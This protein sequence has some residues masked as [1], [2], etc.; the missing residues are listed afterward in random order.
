MLRVWCA[1]NREGRRLAPRQGAF[2]SKLYN[3]HPK[4]HEPVRRARVVRVD[5]R[6]RGTVLC[7]SAPRRGCGGGRSVAEVE[8]APC[9]CTHHEEQEEREVCVCVC[10]YV[11]VC[12]CLCVFVCLCVCVCVCVCARACVCVCVIVCSCSRR[13]FLWKR[14]RE[15]KALINQRTSAISAS[16]DTCTT[17]RAK[18]RPRVPCRSA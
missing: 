17:P 1:A 16:F 14:E 5:A 12:L 7:R 6:A 10:V 8:V 13:K 18:H 15:I 11:C 3:V 2:E 4:E 9:Q